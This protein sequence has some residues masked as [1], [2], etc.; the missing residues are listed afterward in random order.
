MDILAL[1]HEIILVPGLRFVDTFARG[2]CYSFFFP[3]LFL[4]DAS[5]SRFHFGIRYLVV[6]P[7]FHGFR[8]RPTSSFL[9]SFFPTLSSF[10]ASRIHAIGLS[11]RTRRIFFLLLSFQRNHGQRRRRGSRLKQKDRSN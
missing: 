4:V 5:A 6:A 2:S 1:A 9:V 11:N 8:P 3:R 10:P 7:F